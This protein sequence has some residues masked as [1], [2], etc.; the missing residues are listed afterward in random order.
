MSENHDKKVGRL[1]KLG[2]FWKYEK[3]LL[4]LFD[5]TIYHYEQFLRR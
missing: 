4:K 2:R 5:D 3:M 1:F